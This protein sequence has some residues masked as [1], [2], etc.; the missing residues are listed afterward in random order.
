ML[1][2]MTKPQSPEDVA[3]AMLDLWRRQMQTPSSPPET[4][5]ANAP[6]NRDELAL[7]MEPVS[8]M[9]AVWTAMMDQ[10]SDAARPQTLHPTAASRTAGSAPAGA[11]HDHG[12]LDVAQLAARLEQ[13]ER[14][15]ATLES[16]AKGKRGSPARRRR[17][18][19]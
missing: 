16:G 11:A 9:V 10:F 1:A 12:G 2:R 3:R 8:H 7:L 4:T 17:A 15:L 5:V 13:I 14:R 6:L 18:P 19:S